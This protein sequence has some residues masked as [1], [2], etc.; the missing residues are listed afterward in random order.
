MNARRFKLILPVFIATVLL[1]LLMGSFSLDLVE[2]AYP[3][4]VII[5]ADETWDSDQDITTDVV[6]SSGASLTIKG[7][8]TVTAAAS[9]PAP[10]VS[11]L[12]PKIEIIVEDSGTL[13]VEPGATLTAD[14]PG[15]WYGVV[16]LS[17]SDGAGA[18]LTTVDGGGVDSVFAIYS[19]ALLPRRSL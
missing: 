6:V 12:S 8:V 3:H 4:G 17:G 19:A 14:Q 13:I 9:D 15:D 11:G 2:A 18:G 7:G 10:Y 16:F 1:I 5:S